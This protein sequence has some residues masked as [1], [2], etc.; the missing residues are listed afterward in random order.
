MWPKNYF[1]VVIRCNG[2]VATN[3]P[4]TL[5]VRVSVDGWAGKKLILSLSL[6]CFVCVCVRMCLL[7]D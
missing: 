1:N 6:S 4:V 3:G 5:H 7:V 2:A